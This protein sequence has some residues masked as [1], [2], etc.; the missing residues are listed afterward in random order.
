MVASKASDAAYRPLDVDLK[1]VL[2]PRFA[3]QYGTVAVPLRGPMGEG[4]STG[5]SW[6]EGNDSGWF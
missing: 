3:L 2:P 6:L 5:T 4:E 1:Q